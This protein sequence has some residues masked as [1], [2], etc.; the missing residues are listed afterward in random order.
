MF[1]NLALSYPPEGSYLTLLYYYTVNNYLRGFMHVGNSSRSVP[2][3]R[4]LGEASLTI[5]KFHSGNFV[6]LAPKSKI[7]KEFNLKPK[8]QNLGLDFIGFGV[9][10]NLIAILYAGICGDL[11]FWICMDSGR[12]IS[13]VSAHADR[14]QFQ[15]PSAFKDN[16]DDDDDG[17]VPRR[18]AGF[19]KH[20]SVFR[21]G[22]IGKSRKINEKKPW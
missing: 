12:Y 4:P 18:I 8:S 5:T 14:G 13:R 15:K 2:R 11:G 17:L 16:N 1:K 3:N 6:G 9:L 19:A 20:N 10:S 21:I 7:K 22:L